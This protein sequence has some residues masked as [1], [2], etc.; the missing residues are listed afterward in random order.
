MQQNHSDIMDALSKH[1][2]DTEGSQVSPIETGEMNQ[3]M[4]F[5]NQGLKHAEIAGIHHT[6]GDYTNAHA[7]MVTA[8]Q[9]FGHAEMI[10]RGI[11][12]RN[13]GMMNFVGGVGIS[14]H[15]K[16]W[17]HVLADAYGQTMGL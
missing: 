2:L 5:A 11:R 14:Q 12:D 7:S 16:P 6:A 4:H 8:G 13:H 9:H 15:G 17:G 10:L 1:G 3:V